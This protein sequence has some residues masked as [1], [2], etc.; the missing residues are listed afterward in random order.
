M[1]QTN[2]YSITVKSAADLAK[3]H[4]YFA[5]IVNDAD[6]YFDINVVLRA[7]RMLFNSDQFK[8]CVETYGA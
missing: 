8:I 1:V 7:L 4:I 5:R 3:P 6:D 2:S